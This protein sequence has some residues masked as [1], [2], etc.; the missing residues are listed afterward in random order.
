MNTKNTPKN[1]RKCRICLSAEKAVEP[2][3]DPDTCRWS[4]C[5]DPQGPKKELQNRLEKGSMPS[6]PVFAKIS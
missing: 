2:E 6:R 4:P 3:G 1:W 5:N